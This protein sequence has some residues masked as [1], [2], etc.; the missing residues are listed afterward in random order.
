MG[1]PISLGY[2]RTHGLSDAQLMPTA[3]G[4]QFDFD[5]F[6]VE[7]IL[8]HHSVLPTE[9][10]QKLGDTLGAD[11]P[12]PSPEEQQW[13]VHTG[14]PRG[15][16]LHRR[17]SQPGLTWRRPRSWVA[18]FKYRET[19]VR[20][21]RGC[22][23]ASGTSIALTRATRDDWGSSPVRQKEPCHSTDRP[24]DVK[25]PASPRPMPLR[26]TREV[27]RPVDEIPLGCSER[28]DL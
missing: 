7:A 3:G 13:F 21:H 18:N 12:Q 8:A 2:L 22:Q 14:S 17:S 19:L 25:K 16:Q 26:D 5:G 27:V 15:P 4:E 1:T 9:M 20:R 28:A 6:T 11:S 10:L 23:A 24:E